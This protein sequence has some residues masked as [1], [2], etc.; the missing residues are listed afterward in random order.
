[1]FAAAIGID[2]GIEA[3]IGVTK[4]EE[5]G[6]QQARARGEH[7]AKSYLSHNEGGAQAVVSGDIGAAP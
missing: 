7:Q 4:V 2:A 3:D 5:A 6:D 1:M